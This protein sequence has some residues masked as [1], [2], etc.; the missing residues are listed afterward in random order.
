MK[1]QVFRTNHHCCGH[2]MEKPNLP[3]LTLNLND[4]KGFVISDY[5]FRLPWHSN[6]MAHV[7]TFTWWKTVQKFQILHTIFLISYSLSYISAPLS[8]TYC[9]R[10]VCI[11]YSPTK[12]KTN[13]PIDKHHDC[14]YTWFSGLVVIVAH[15]QIRFSRVIVRMRCLALQR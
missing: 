6:L 5:N 9:F 11:V 4:N 1:R 10:E 7:S 2:F 14:W 12:P 13:L 3:Q 15:R 8:S